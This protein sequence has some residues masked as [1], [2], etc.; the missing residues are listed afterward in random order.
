MS[1]S[2]KRRRADSGT[3]DKEAVN[4]ASKK[5]RTQ[6]QRK[7]IGP[8]HFNFGKHRGKTIEEVWDSYD[9]SYIDEFLIEKYLTGQSD[10]LVKKPE[11]LVAL[12]NIP[13]AFLDKHPR[14]REALDRE[15]VSLGGERIP[16][17]FEHEAMTE[18]GMMRMN[19]RSEGLKFWEATDRSAV[20]SL[21]QNA[22]TARLADFGETIRSSPFGS[23]ASP[24]HIY[25]TATVVYAG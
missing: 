20:L 13:E 25:F 7:K 15:P 23:G 11:I 19:E 4:P 2:S 16:P 24:I 8:Y 3:R 14:L 10:L 17:I 12:R 1:S 6:P 5:R 21:H 22:P 18:R 9:S